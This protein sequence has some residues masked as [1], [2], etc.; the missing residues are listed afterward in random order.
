MIIYIKNVT[1][2]VENAINQETT[3]IIIVQSVL[4]IILFSMIHLI[5]SIIVI[6]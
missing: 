1:K 5:I 2:H 4:I 3:H 6:L